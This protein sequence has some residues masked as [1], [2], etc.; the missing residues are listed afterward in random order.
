MSDCM[1]MKTKKTVSEAEKKPEAE[2]NGEFM[3]LRSRRLDK[4]AAAL[5]VLKKRGGRKR[6]AE[7]LEENNVKE[8]TVEV[9][10]SV[11]EF[12][13]GGQNEI[14]CFDG[15]VENVG[16]GGDANENGGGGGGGDGVAAA[17][18]TGE[19]LVPNDRAIRES[20]PENLII[21]APGD[22]FAAARPRIS[23]R[24]Q[25]GCKPSAKEMEDFFAAFEMQQ[26]KHF[27]EKYN[28]DFKNETPLPG[29]YEWVKVEP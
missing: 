26:D 16:G 10:D 8:T 19:I 17:E 13:V 29:R 5:M 22:D 28:F 4:S 27:A 1:M 11:A 21:R 23:R 18:E 2:E 9:G 24:L 3:Q 15:V 25:G 12:D 7:K 14:N 6:K 20:T